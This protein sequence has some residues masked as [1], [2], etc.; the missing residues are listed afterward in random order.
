MTM[1][2]ARDKAIDEYVGA[3]PGATKYEA[4]SKLVCYASILASA[5]IICTFML[6][7]VVVWEETGG[8]EATQVIVM[9]F[10]D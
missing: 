8:S 4:L 1:M 2:A 7:V 3:H 10:T 9:I 6:D 5:S